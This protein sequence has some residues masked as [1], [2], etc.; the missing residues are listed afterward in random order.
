M[1]SGRK[2]NPMPARDPDGKKRQLLDAALT[3]F[4]SKG[5]AGARVDEIARLAAC[6]AGLVYAYFGSKEGLFDAV[7]DDITTRAMDGTPID[8]ADLPGYASHA[9]TDAAAHPEIGRFAAWHQLER[10]A[11]G[12]GRET[13]VSATE[14]KIRIVQ[15]AQD[16]GSIS[17]RLPAAELLLAIQALSR[18]WLTMPEEVVATVD[19][20]NSIDARA[21]AVRRAVEALLE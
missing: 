20:G 12:I 15:K 9:Y 5:L 13:V 16:A 19:P 6:S 7:L 3:A 18:M 14:E 8:T 4:A 1:R 2:G 10:H 21:R 17:S 11:D